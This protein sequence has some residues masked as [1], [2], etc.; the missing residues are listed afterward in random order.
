MR[1]RYS[2][3]SRGSYASSAIDHLAG[4]L[5][6][7]DLLVAI[8]AEADAGRLAVGVDDGH[9][10][11]VDRRFLVL[12]AA[13]RVELGR[14]GMALNHVQAFHHDAALLGEHLQDGALTA[15]VLAGEDHDAVPLL[16]LRGHHSTS[17]AR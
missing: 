13:L 8:H 14:T 2:V 17:G 9:V 6:D 7:T 11:Q 16:D 1:A 10:R 12:D 5:G 3:L 4:R 15:L